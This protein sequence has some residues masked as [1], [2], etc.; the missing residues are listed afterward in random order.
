MKIDHDIYS[1]FK[2]NGKSHT[3]THTHTGSGARRRGIVGE[4]C[5]DGLVLGCWLLT[6]SS[7]A[8]ATISSSSLYVR[9][10]PH[11]CWIDWSN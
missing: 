5:M 9:M 8:R 6:T 11:L 2:A 1:Q 10:Y 4:G 3:N 7:S